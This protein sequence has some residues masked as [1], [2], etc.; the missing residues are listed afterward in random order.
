[1]RAVDFLKEVR[2]E[3]SKVT[4]PTLREVVM[5]SAFVL[6]ATGIAGIVLLL[7]DSGIYKLIKIFL[8]IGG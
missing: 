2:R 3:V 4:W 1:M 7:V 6:F 8:G 5:T